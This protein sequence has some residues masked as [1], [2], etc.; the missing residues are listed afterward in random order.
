MKIGQ[1]VGAHG[2]R[3]QV[4]IEPE[5]HYL[6]YLEKG[7][8]VTIDGKPHIVETS[9][10]HK[11]RPLIKFAAISTMNQAEALQWKDIEISDDSPSDLGEDEFLAEDLIGMRVVTESGTELGTVDD[12]L[13]NPAHDIIVVGEVLI[14]A[15]KEFI[16]MI[17]F[18][19]ELITVRLIPGMLPGEIAE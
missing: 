13:A 4:K 15:I 17:D 18:E 10:I 9:T 19:A 8:T 11:G 3:G 14:P 5:R 1:I 7:R 2:I 12:T 16:T 6:S